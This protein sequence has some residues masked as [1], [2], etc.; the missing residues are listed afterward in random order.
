MKGWRRYGLTVALVGGLGLAMA[1]GL[2]PRGATS[3]QAAP[4]AQAA[5][6]GSG[7]WSG[8]LDNLAAA[9]GIQR[10]ALDSAISSAGEATLDEAVAAGTLTQEQADAILPRVQAGDLGA[11]YGGR[12]GP[13]G[14]HGG[15]RIAGLHQ[16]MRDAAASALGITSDELS[17]ALR[18]G[19]TLAEL[20]AANGVGE[21][22]VID[23]ALA[24]ADTKLDEAVA[25]GT[26][27]QEQADAIYARLE[28]AG[29]DLLGHAGRGG[30]GGRGGPRAPGADETAPS[31][32]ETTTTPAAESDA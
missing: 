24:A 23:A 19:Q 7:L 9:L 27:T 31:A 17:S 2:A 30:P 18:G 13:G 11:V 28:A 3:A 1:F 12:G 5:E 25:A 14:R 15:A 8:F 20:A 4:A 16:A 10:S 32:P 22:A 29:A 21:Q 6:G 26:L